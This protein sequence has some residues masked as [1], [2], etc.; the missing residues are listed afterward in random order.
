[1][2]NNIQNLFMDQRSY[3]LIQNKNNFENMISEILKSIDTTQSQPQT[4]ILDGIEFETEFHPKND[5]FGFT[6]TKDGYHYVYHDK[7]RFKN[8]VYLYSPTAK[9]EYDE[10]FSG[11]TLL[12]YTAK[13]FIYVIP[14][15]ENDL[16]KMDC[17]T[18]KFT[19]RNS[20]VTAGY[21][22]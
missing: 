1:M 3:E 17:A 18:G 20:K 12:L 16:S 8:S 19:K 2:K 4:V 21:N 22:C 5:Y 10:D 9:E 6:Y 7:N 13:K 11:E 14:Y 15:G